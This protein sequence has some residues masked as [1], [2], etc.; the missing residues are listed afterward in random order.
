MKK[1]ILVIASMLV[2]LGANAVPAYR[3]TRTV[4]QSDGSTIEIIKH[5][6]EHFHYVTDTKGQW[7]K[8]DANGNY[9]PTLA[10]TAEQIQAKRLQSPKLKSQIKHVQQSAQTAIPL[11]IAD[12]GLIILVNFSDK[13]FD[14]ANSLEAMQEMHSGEN[15]S[16]EGATGSAREYFYDQSLGRYNPQFDVVGPITLSQKSSYYG[17]NDRDGNDQRAHTMVIEA[18]KAADQNFGVDF[19]KY[20]NNN[21]GVVD[22]VYII[23]AGLGEAD[24][25]S[26]TTIW[27]HAWTLDE[28][29]QYYGIEDCIVDN[30]RINTYACGP[31]L[32]G[33][34]DRSGIGTFCHEF[35]HVCGLPDL[36]ATNYEE[37]KTMGAW[38][39]LDYGPYNNDGN[40]P[41]AYSAYERFFCGWLTPEY[42]NSPADLSLEEIQSANKA[43]IVTTSKQPNLIGNDP[44]P[45]T[46]YLI[47][48]R[49][50]VGWDKYLPGHGMLLT[51]IAY[52]YNTWTGNTV[53]DVASSMG[54][55][56]IEA[57]GNAVKATGDDA[58]YTSGYFG[59]ATD[60]FPAGA[61][62]YT[63]ITNRSITDIKENNGI[64][65]F[66]FMGG[67]N[68]ETPDTTETPT[69]EGI[70]TVAQAIDIAQNLAQNETSTD[71]VEV[72]GEITDI[73][74]VETSKY[75]NASFTIKDETGSIY[76]YH[77]YYLNNQKF[78]SQDQIQIG[79]KVIVR[80]LVKNYYSK[81]GNTTYELVNGYIKEIN[82]IISGV[83]NVDVQTYNLIASDGLLYLTEPAGHKMQVHN[84]IGQTLYI[85]EATTLT[86][87]HGIYI[88]RIDN[89]IYKVKL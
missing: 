11:N 2:T 36:Y 68:G 62:S 17:S 88:V 29:K 1:S 18:C 9:V 55:D 32:N 84:A 74:E 21:D 20:D 80:C 3:G 44:D 24:G 53:N 25:G 70:I 15:Y 19:T 89:N 86:L 83:E 12:Y 23:Y 81:S 42:I 41:A 67:A 78:S 13:K 58:D 30:K 87:P 4:K 7:L 51:K 72:Y 43:Y 27:P 49:Q 39:I 33:N 6:D 75:G 37:H 46:F 65:S 79:D 50:N 35:S 52:S 77:I 38:D 31:E 69:P 66:K 60:A 40:T 10:M 8:E 54:V 57:D 22:F 76:C 5:G 82:P 85:G 28:A 16:Y 61:T 26:S 73:K 56:L 59:K 45:T 14:S 63:K 34:Y 48:N 47:E 64:I 71:T